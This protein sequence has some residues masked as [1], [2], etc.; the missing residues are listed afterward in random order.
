VQVLLNSSSSGSNWV[1]VGRTE[2]IMN[3]ANPV[4]AT[5]VQIDFRFEEKQ[6]V[7]ALSAL[8]ALCCAVLCSAVACCPV[9]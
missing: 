6:T 7:S 9:S 8:S 2:T 4:F 3:T 5:M 1:E